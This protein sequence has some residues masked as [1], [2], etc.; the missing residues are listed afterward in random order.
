MYRIIIE[1]NEN[2]E[3]Y[4]SY[5]IVTLLSYA[6]LSSAAINFFLIETFSLHAK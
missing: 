5:Q 3:T 1:I 4:I 6:F 2:N